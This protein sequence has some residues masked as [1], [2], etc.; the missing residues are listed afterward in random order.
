MLNRQRLLTWI[1]RVGFGLLLLVFGELVAWQYASQ[2]DAF[3][4]IALIGLYFAMAAILLDV[5]VRW[6]VQDV[7]GL[8]LVAGIFGLTESALISARLFDNL[9]ISLVFYGTGLETVMFLLAF[10]SFLYLSTAR[11]ASA[12]LVGL[13]ALVGLGWGIWVR[14]YPELEHVQQAVPSLDVALPAVVIA[15]L[16]NLLV[17]FV[18]PPP[19]KMSFQD[20]LLEPYEWAA[21]GGILGVTLALRL[22]DGSIPG[23]GIALVA[24]I[25][26]MIVL[27]LWFT[28]QTHKE[29]W[30]RFLNPPQQ[31]LLYGWI[32]MLIAF[33]LMGW[34]GY[35]LPQENDN[36][37]QTTILFGLLVFFGAIWLPVV[38]VLIGIRTFTQ[39][40]R[41]EY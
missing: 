20:W 26:T 24:M 12:W 31:P 2:Y 29:N 27:I 21:A 23:V 22:V 17:L 11:P 36:P 5:M 38:S 30:L 3:D 41:E 40:A 35:H 37:I 28:R 7:L 39:L 25:I 4:W 34:A 15:L 10:G 18:V 13:A 9:P 16:G 19:K 1:P 8:L 14:G 6:H 33:M 32:Y